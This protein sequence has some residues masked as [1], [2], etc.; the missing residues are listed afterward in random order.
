MKKIL[1]LLLI[2]SANLSSAQESVL[3]R[4]N[5]EEGATYNVN[6]KM[7]QNMGVVMSMGTNIEMSIKVLQV[8]EDSYDSEMRFTKMTMDMLQGGNV[9]SFDSSKSDD[10]LD[11]VGKMM[12]AQMGPMLKAKMLVKG[13]NLG[14]IISLK[15]DPVVP[16]MEDFAKQSSTVIYPKKALRVGDSWTT[17]KSEKGIK[18][19]YVYTVKSITKYKVVLDLSG[20]ISEGATGDIT[21]NMIIERASGIPVNSMMDMNMTVSGQAL[22]SQISMT[23]TKQ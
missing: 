20:K 17:S 6:M 10:E 21:G 13:N 12:K 9:M 15:L 19:D 7:S 2:I 5:Y 22:K 23:I 11:E 1:I 4:L 3:L 8:F 16:G 18:M 14:D